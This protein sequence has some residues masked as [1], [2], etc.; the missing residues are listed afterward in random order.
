MKKRL[1]AVLK[2]VFFMGLGI[3]LVWWSIARMDEKSLENCKA[4]MRTARYLLFVPVFFILAASHVSRAMRWKI[5]MQPLG[6]RPRLLNTF[7]AVMVGYLANLAVP[8]LGEVLKCTILSR[9]EKVPAD[10][11]VG[12]MIVERAVD[13]VSLLLV[14]IIA[15][16]TQA[17]IIG[18]YAKATMSKYFLSGSTTVLLIKF[19]VL[20][21]VLVVLFFISR[22]LLKK[23]SH[24][25]PVQKIAGVISGIKDGLASIKNLQQKGAFIFHSV[26]IWLCYAGGTWLGF[27]ATLGTEGLPFAAAFPVLAFASIGMIITP[28]GIGTYP[29]LIMEVMALY[30]IDE[31]IGFANG[32]LQWLAQFGIIL[33]V[34]FISLLL[35]P[36]VNKRNSQAVAAA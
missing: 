34:G 27:Y 22:L 3:F 7:F 32:N 23:Y 18:S 9:Y 24:I 25:G 16:L 1:L 26:F 13:V 11:L 10:K 2:F 20:I 14:F 31:G 30:N 19:T 5:L 36:Y 33:I 4:A 35:L 6:Y 12:T 29:L 17:H 8:R 21:T 15:L 28:G